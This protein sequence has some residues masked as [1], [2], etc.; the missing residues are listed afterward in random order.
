M[1]QPIPIIADLPVDEPGLGFDAYAKALADT[2]QG[3]EPAQFTVGIYGSWGTGKSS[4]LRAVDRELRQSPGEVVPIGFD[5]WRYER[6][7]YIVVPLLHRIANSLGDSFGSKVSEQIRKALRA[8]MKSLKFNLG[9]IEVDAS[10]LTEGSSEDLVSLD[11]AFAKP[12]D[13]LRNI[14]DLLGE[15]R[16]IAVL[17]DDLDRCSPEK[18][19]GLLESIN[20]V[21]DIPGFVFVLA[22][23]YDVLVNAIEIR[24]PHLERDKGLGHA[25]IEKMVQVPFRVPPLDIT[26]NMLG[27]LIPQIEGFE[28]LPEGFESIAA[29]VS[30]VGLEANPRR[31]K[32][33]VNAFLLLTR[34]TADRDI[35]VDP[36]L[37]A[38]IIGLQLRWPDEHQEL[39]DRMS[40]EEDL[41]FAEWRG[42]DDAALKRYCSRFFEPPPDVATL[43]VLVSLTQTVAGP[44]SG[45]VLSEGRPA[46][47]ERELSRQTMI[48]ELESRGFQV[49]PNSRELF[50]SSAHPKLGVRLTKH[51]IRIERRRGDGSWELVNPRTLYLTRHVD[52]ALKILDSKLAVT[53]PTSA[54]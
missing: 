46:S 28:G 15:K 14:G 6:E 47:E 45:I 40:Y 53:R 37:A 52:D 44:S 30:S 13:E 19:V 50:R 23:D 25:F 51:A 32:R 54:R 39:A 34:I 10:S 18:V 31:I 17:I 41:P 24:Y 22:L 11:E 9:V 16:R 29:D 4:L 42:A 26:E 38:A 1:R 35:N 5:A 27:A 49:A 2:I 21:M 33:F 43:R 3:G 20:L 12:F 36:R 48:K 7:P 8:V